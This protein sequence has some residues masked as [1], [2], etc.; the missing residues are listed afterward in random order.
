MT[1]ELLKILKRIRDEGPQ[2][3]HCGICGNV[4]TM[5]ADETDEMALLRELDKTIR[6][7]PAACKGED[8]FPVEGESLQFFKDSSHLILW[9]NPRRHELL[10]WLIKELECNG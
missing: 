4:N 7:W 5:A 1:A 10:D 6:K 8:S 9:Q 3:P 2:L